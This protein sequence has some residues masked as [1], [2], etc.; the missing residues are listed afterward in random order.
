MTDAYAQNY[1]AAHASFAKVRAK[2]PRAAKYHQ[3]YGAAPAPGNPPV[4]TAPPVITAM[5]GVNV[6]DTLVRNSFGSWTGSPTF[7]SQWLRDTAPIFNATGSTYVLVAADAGAMITLGVVG[8][9]ADGSASVA[10]NALGPVT[11]V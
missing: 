11:D 5:T 9:N 1:A 6:G 3:G 8:T 10:S 2:M 7:A 4:N